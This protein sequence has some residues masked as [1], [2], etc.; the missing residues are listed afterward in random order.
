MQPE[1][2]LQLAAADAN[3]EWCNR[4]WNLIGYRSYYR[5]ESN[6]DGIT[7]KEDKGIPFYLKFGEECVAVLTIWEGHDDC[8]VIGTYPKRK[9][10]HRKFFFRLCT[11]LRRQG[12]RF[13]FGTP[14]ETA[15]A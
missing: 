12:V 9:S 8:F 10:E 6:P 4:I 1:H 7:Y 15:G 2:A 3:R 5:C 13:A 11:K 14:D